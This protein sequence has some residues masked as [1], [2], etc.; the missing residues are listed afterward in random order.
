MNANNISDYHKL[1]EVYIQRVVDMISD[2]KS[3]PLVWQ[4]VFLNGV[5]LPNGTVVQAWTGNQELL[6]YDV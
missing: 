5:N 1:E 3:N 6:L 2:L 4:E